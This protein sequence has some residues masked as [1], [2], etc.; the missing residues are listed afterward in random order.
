M[1]LQVSKRADA[2]HP[3]HREFYFYSH[4]PK[5]TDD[6]FNNNKWRSVRWAAGNCS[7]CS[8]LH[9]AR[10]RAGKL[11]LSDDG[12]ARSGFHAVTAPLRMCLL[13][14]R[15]L[16][17]ITLIA[18]SHEHTAAMETLLTHICRRCYYSNFYFSTKKI[19]PKNADGAANSM[20]D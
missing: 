10:R 3:L 2:R 9:F 8:E 20:V 19:T 13:L 18:P 7:I 14:L 17:T 15:V 11:L 4:P 16:S 5:A 1:L 12:T 6:L